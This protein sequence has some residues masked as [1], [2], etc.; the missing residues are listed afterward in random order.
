VTIGNIEARDE[1]RSRDH[2]QGDRRSY[3]RNLT[4]ATK[5]EQ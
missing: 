5:N 2:C 4:G 3:D 1:N